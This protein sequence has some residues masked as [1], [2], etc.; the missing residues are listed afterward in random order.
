VVIDVLRASSTIVTALAHGVREIRAVSGVAEALALRKKKYVVAGERQCLMVPGFDLGNSP[1][2]LLRA[3][4]K[5][6]I[7][8]MALTTSNL[9]RVLVACRS[10]VICSSLNLTAVSKVIADV[11]VNIVAVGG[12]HGIVEDLGVALALLLKVQ[13]VKLDKRLVRHMILQSPAAQH[14]VGIGYGN[15]VKFVC[16]VDRYTA[17]PVYEKGRVVQLRSG[18]PLSRGW[19]E[20]GDDD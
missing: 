20:G 19:Q 9:T 7:S 1:V 16:A 12:P 18:S 2:E 5:R 10:A 3:L 17:V 13:G 15:D 11:D 14:L 6:A 8:K 4:R